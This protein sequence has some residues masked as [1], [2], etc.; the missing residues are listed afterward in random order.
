MLVLILV[1]L[2]QSHML[3]TM[4]D[5]AFRSSVISVGD[6]NFESSSSTVGG[7]ILESHVVNNGD[8]AFRSSVIPVGDS[9]F[10]SS[11]STVGGSILESSHLLYQSV[12]RI[13]SHQVLLWVTQ[14]LSHML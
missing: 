14:F 5:L 10:E 7:S 12:T 2:L 6:S 8:L 11:G 13:L 3:Y 1:A 4:G 9:N